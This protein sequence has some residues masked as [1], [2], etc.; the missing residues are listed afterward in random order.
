MEKGR[1]RREGG[2]ETK[3]LIIF[4]QCNWEVEDS[5]PPIN[6]EASKSSKAAPLDSASSTKSSKP[7]RVSYLTEQ[8]SHHPPVS[9]FF[10]DCPEK[11]ISA[12]GFD[13][14]SAKF[15]GTSIKVTPGEHNLG[16][17]ITLHKRDEEVYQLTH[18]AAHL[19][20]LM[21]GSLSVTVG[22]QCYVTCPKTKL[23]VILHYVEEGWLGKTQNRVE[24]VVFRYDPDNDKYT[25][26]RDVPEKDILAKVSG[27]WKEKLYFSVGPSFSVSPPYYPTQII[28]NENARFDKSEP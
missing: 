2:F 22:D 15:T 4:S 17:F 9:A 8:T 5:L 14:L 19:G 12:R 21:R 23:K 1:K 25:R 10:V 18:P 26:I 13:Q 3:I 20:G 28:A 24:G 27:N 16:I 11:G 7:V 6:V